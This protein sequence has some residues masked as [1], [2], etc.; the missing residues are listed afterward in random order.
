MEVTE[1][2][3]ILSELTIVC[4]FAAMIFAGFMGMASTM[5]AEMVFGIA[6]LLSGV[7]FVLSLTVEARK[8][9]LK[10]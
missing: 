5:G 1:M 10:A 9:G 7:V 4:L 6:A 3:N 8:L 2:K